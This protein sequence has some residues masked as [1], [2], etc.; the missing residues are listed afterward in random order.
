MFPGSLSIH[1]SSTIIILGQIKILFSLDRLFEQTVSPS[2]GLPP[3]HSILPSAVKH[4]YNSVVILLKKLLLLLIIGKWNQN[5][6]VHNLN[7][8]IV[9]LFI[10]FPAS[11]L[12]FPMC[13][14]YAMFIS[15]LFPLGR[16]F[17]CSIHHGV[18]VYMYT[19]IHTCKHMHTYICI[20]LHTFTSHYALSSLR[21]WLLN[22]VQNW[23]NVRKYK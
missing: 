9:W 3:L 10:T 20:S 18:C 6:W 11:I 17:H 22:T 12:V 1:F 21:Q 23:K 15:V 13:P 14:N 4:K 16:G 19:Y 8:F 2:H 5:L 7:L